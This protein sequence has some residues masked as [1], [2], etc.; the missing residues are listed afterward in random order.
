MEQIYV[1]IFTTRPQ[2]LTKSR[3]KLT[4]EF[5][6]DQLNSLGERHNE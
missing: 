6:F 3:S 2:K 1:H 5:N 4:K